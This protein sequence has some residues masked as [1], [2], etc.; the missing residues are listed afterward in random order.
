MFSLVIISINNKLI[1]TLYDLLDL[2]STKR[3]TAT[4]TNAAT[5]TTVTTTQINHG[6]LCLPRN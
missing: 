3:E 4:T 2:Q 6:T 5:A 1:C